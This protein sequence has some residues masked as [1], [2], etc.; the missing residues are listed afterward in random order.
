[1]NLPQNH[2][3]IQTHR[4]LAVV[5]PVNYEPDIMQVI[6]VFHYSEELGK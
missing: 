1:M 5:T 2:C 4:R 6:S 3:P